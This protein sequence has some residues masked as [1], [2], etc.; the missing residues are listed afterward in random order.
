MVPVERGEERGGRREGGR[1]ERK[2]EGEEGG[3]RGREKR[4]GEEG[5]GYVN[6]TSIR[7]AVSV[8]GVCVVN[9]LTC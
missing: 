1:R 9:P 2:E 8:T 7:P 3:R 5:G 6:G 4:E